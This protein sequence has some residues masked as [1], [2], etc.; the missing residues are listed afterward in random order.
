M[1]KK[2]ADL[3][4]L[5]LPPGV[6]PD[7]EPVAGAGGDREKPPKY[8]TPVPAGAGGLPRV[9]TQL[10]RAGNGETRFK[11]RCNNYTPRKVRYILAADG[12]EAGARACYLKAEGL[13]KEIERLK[14]VAGSKASEVEEPDLV[15]TELPD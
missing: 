2:K 15:I 4:T 9:V 7:G 8:G 5:P 12:D 1:S 11:V 13:D 14:K 10:A 3:D 6:P